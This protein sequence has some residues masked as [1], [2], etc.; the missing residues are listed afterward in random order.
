MRG[1]DPVLVRNST[2]ILL[3]IQSNIHITILTDS[4]SL[5]HEDKN[6]TSHLVVDRNI[7]ILS[8]LVTN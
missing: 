1:Q 5:V 4:A 2:R 6:V 3:N 7:E 8:F